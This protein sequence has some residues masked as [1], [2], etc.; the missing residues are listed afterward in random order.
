MIEATGT[1]FEAQPAPKSEESL[2][3]ES[4]AKRPVRSRITVIPYTPSNGELVPVYIG[5]A[6]SLPDEISTVILDSQSNFVPHARDRS[7]VV[8]LAH[9]AQL[10]SLAGIDSGLQKD[11]AS[12]IYTGPIALD[13]LDSFADTDTPTLSMGSARITLFGA[14]TGKAAYRLNKD[15]LEMMVNGDMITPPELTDIIQTMRDNP[16]AGRKAFESFYDGLPRTG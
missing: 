5:P 15:T 7:E 10:A 2:G 1:P 8:N 9:E 11:E 12:D 13:H 16:R 14:L 3:G 6:G 4:L